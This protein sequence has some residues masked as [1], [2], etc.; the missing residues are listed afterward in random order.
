MSENKKPVSKYRA[1][2]IIVSVWENEGGKGTYHTFGLQRSYKDPDGQWKTS[3]SL[4]AGDLVIAA[5][6]LRQAFLDFG[7]KTVNPAGDEFPF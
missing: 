1:N 5:E 2:G 7:M 6:L 4:R 3:P